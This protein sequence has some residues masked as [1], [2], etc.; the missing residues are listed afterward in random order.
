VLSNAKIDRLA[1]ALP[2][3]PA[4]LMQHAEGIWARTRAP[5]PLAEAAVAL[6]KAAALAPADAGAR[7]RAARV[8]VALAEKA[9]ESE[10]RRALARRGATWAKAALGVAPASTEGLYYLGSALGLA[11]SAELAPTLED[12]S[13]IEEPFVRLVESAPG[14]EQ[15]GPLRILGTLYMQAPPWPAGVGDVDEGMVLLERAIREFPDHPL[16]H[17]FIA[18]AFVKLGQRDRA[19]S[20]L[21]RV[22]SFPKRG[23]WA[24]VG[25]QYRAEAR[26]L[27]RDV[28][29]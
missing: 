29:R 17:L 25:S 7:W 6:E 14:F 21:E 28:S 16:N 1:A 2:D 18:K 23:E 9:R 13:A 8:Y 4:A 27:L 24:L 20:P 26:Q 12:Q 10:A 3:D 22:L 19:R 15:G 5:R 11:A